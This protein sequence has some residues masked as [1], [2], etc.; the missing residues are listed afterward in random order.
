MKKENKGIIVRIW[1][2][3]K[4]LAILAMGLVV[5]FLVRGFIVRRGL[6]ETAQ[7]KKGE[8]VEELVLSGEVSA[9]EYAKLAFATSGKISWVGVSEGKEVRRGQALAKL[10]TTNLNSDYQ[11]ALEDLRSAE[12]SLQ[13]T[14]DDVKGHDKDET[15]TQKETRTIDEVAKN[16]AYEAVIQ[17]RNNLANATLIAPFNG[18]V[19]FVANPFSGVNTLASQTQIELINPE[20]IYFN[21]SAD[22]SEVTDLSLGQKVKIILDPY[23]EQEFEGEVIFVSYTPKEG[24]VGT[25]YKVK[26]KFEAVEPNVGKFRIG[27]SGDAGFI[28][29][30]KEAVL[31]VPPKFINSDSKGKYVKKGRTNNKTY[32]ETGIEA[33]DR[34]EIVTG[35]SEGDTLYD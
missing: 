2:R 34:V 1:A 27:M 19:T 24:E 5:F 12:A 31:W 35:V 33:E 26:V 32:V 15:L 10:D 11:R 18:L 22:Q 23:P 7:V 29:S 20:T 21:V 4:L 3:K 8:V 16:K 17:A 6:V 14:Y 13:K 28:L 30:K 25:V 9:D